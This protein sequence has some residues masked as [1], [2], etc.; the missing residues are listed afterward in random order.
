MSLV[1]ANAV[2]VPIERRA[3]QSPA[4][5]AP[6]PSLRACLTSRTGQLF[7]AGMT[8]TLLLSAELTSACELTS[9]SIGWT[10]RS[11]SGFQ[12]KVTSRSPGN[13]FHR[14]PS[15]NS[16]MWL[17]AC[18]RIFTFLPAF[19]VIQRWPEPLQLAML[20][21]L[22]SRLPISS[23]PTARSIAAD[24]GTFFLDFPFQDFLEFDPPY[25]KTGS[26]SLVPS[27]AERPLWFGYA[28]VSISGLHYSALS[29]AGN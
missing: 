10:R 25:G 28:A 3:L 16:T 2:R 4:V 7:V 15:S 24:A 6:Q 27:M 23:V 18:D 13:I 8:R 20:H 9:S 22:I 1:I 11:V 19:G 5:L 12:S 26:R 14:D 29:V 21:R 17:S